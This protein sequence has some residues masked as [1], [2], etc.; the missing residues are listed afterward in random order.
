MIAAADELIP[1]LVV[2]DGTARHAGSSQRSE[3]RAATLEK[4]ARL[5]RTGSDSVRARQTQAS[6]F[7]S[8][9]DALPGGGWQTGSMVEIMPDNIGIGEL[10]LIMPTLARITHSERH[11]A[12]ITPP[13][14]P[15]AAALSQQGLRL[16][17]LLIIRAEKP[18]D[19]LWACEQTL[20][21]RSFGAVIAWP[22][23][24]R[25]RDIRRLQLAA[26]AG[27][28]IGFLYRVPSAVMEASP[29]ATRLRL[30]S[31]PH[32]LSIDILKCRGGRAGLSV[33]VNT[34]GMT[35]QT[36]PPLTTTSLP[37]D[38]ATVAG[39]PI[40]LLSDQLSAVS[41]Q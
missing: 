9:D 40:R 27:H 38:P 16:E 21:C 12:L 6:G 20:R 28:S 7:K 17:H 18:V 19:A 11:V 30:H 26:E 41:G 34:T 31:H 13:H 5:C 39:S 24:I 33:I 29:A 36:S 32:G 23:V 2:S 35:A 37:V 3:S 14:I 15:F 4:L 22:V 1:D 10:R 8:L 25:D